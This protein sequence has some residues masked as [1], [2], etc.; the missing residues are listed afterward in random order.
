MQLELRHIPEVARLLS[1]ER[2]AALTTLTGSASASIDLHQQ[3]LH[4]GASLMTVLATVEI[5]LRNTIADNLSRYF[6]TANW[7][8]QPPAAISWKPPEQ[9]K[10]AHAIDSARRAEYS[11]LSLSAKAALDAL[12][13]PRG[14][15]AGLSPLRRAMDRRRH[16]AVSPGKVIAELTLYF[17]KRL[18][19]PEYEHH[20]WRPT[21]KRTFP[22]RR[23]AR[24][25]VATQLEVI[26]Q[27]RN[28][29]AHHEPV[30]YQRFSSTISA[31]EFVTQRLNSTGPRADAALASLLTDEIARACALESALRA[32]LDAYRT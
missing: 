18:Y 31:I 10:I 8:Q 16:I 25:D 4:V 5:A 13:Y 6:G 14:R 7:L 26:Y 17:W 2:L 1:P 15:P 30:L 12:A 27:T 29:L 21:L 3:T 32:R 19:G 9:D 11:K 28:R 24:S 20:L 23:I 22:D